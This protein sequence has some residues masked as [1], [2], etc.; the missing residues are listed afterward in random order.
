MNATINTEKLLLDLKKMSGASFE[1][2]ALA[3][4]LIQKAFEKQEI[5]QIKCTHEAVKPNLIKTYVLRVDKYHE[6][7]IKIG[8]RIY[9]MNDECT[10]WVG[11]SW[12]YKNIYG[13]KLITML[14]GSRNIYHL[15]ISEKE[16][17]RKKVD[18]EK[19][20]IIDER[21]TKS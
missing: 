16:L 21:N 19:C 6:D 11:I 14:N 8:V 3:L 13:T 4:N 7:D 17:I 10:A 15:E 20:L 12:F 9:P 5:N 1:N 2:E 18:I